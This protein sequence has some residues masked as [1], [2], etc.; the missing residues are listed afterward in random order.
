MSDKVLSFSLGGYLEWVY[1]RINQ[2]GAVK[3]IEISKELNV[4]R[5]SVTEALNKLAQKNYINYGRYEMISITDLGIEKAKEI[6]NKHNVLQ[7]FFENILGIEKNEAAKTACGIEHIIT[8]NI[9]N[10][11]SEFND[12]CVKK[13]DFINLFKQ[14]K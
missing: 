13:T 6:I 2:N 5:A 4:S 12:Y 7:F 3:A 8:E 10:K 11:L 14:G 9:L 1:N